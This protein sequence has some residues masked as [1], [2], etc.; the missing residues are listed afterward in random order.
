MPTNDIKK[1]LLK[2]IEIRSIYDQ[3]KRQNHACRAHT[4]YM[5]IAFRL[6]IT[7]PFFMQLQIFLYPDTPDTES[8][9]T[10]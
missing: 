3:F 5:G 8:F 6:I 9:H 7:L 10:G 1:I 2:N 4:Y